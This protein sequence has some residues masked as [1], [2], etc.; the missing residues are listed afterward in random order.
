MPIDPKAA[1][2]N[3]PEELVELCDMIS[4]RL[5]SANR[6]AMGESKFAWEVAELFKRLG[7]LLT[8]TDDAVWSGFGSGYSAPTLNEEERREKLIELLFPVK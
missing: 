8:E 7:R 5:H 2:F 1:N 4:G 3:G 6:I